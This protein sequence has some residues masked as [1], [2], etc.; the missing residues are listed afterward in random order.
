[1]DFIDN[2]KFVFVCT[3]RVVKKGKEFRRQTV[4]DQT[5]EL[6]VSN[7]EEESGSEGKIM[8]AES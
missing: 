2:F 4:S 1:M 8:E 6:Q 7:R 3:V 5:V